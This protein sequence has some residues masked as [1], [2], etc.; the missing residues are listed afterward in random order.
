[1]QACCR[2]RWCCCCSCFEVRSHREPYG[3]SL[4]RCMHLRRSLKIKRRE[5]QVVEDFQQM[6]WIFFLR[7]LREDTSFTDMAFLADSVPRY[8]QPTHRPDDDDVP[9][10]TK[11]YGSGVGSDLASLHSMSALHDDYWRP[12]WLEDKCPPPSV[13]PIIRHQN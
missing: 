1:M 7:S 4:S 12:W 11:E 8:W 9:G 13:F 3:T 5:S 6:Q 2:R 10:T